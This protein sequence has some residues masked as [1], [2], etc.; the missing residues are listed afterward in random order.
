[1]K[2]NKVLLKLNISNTISVLFF[3]CF[4]AFAKAQIDVTNLKFLPIKEGVSK[5]PISTILQD[6]QGFIWIGTRGSGLYRYDGLNFESYK[7]V[8]GD[9]T[10][11]NSNQIFTMYLDSSDNLWVG[12]DAGLNLFNREQKTF[13]DI[14]NIDSTIQGYTTITAIIEDQD[15]N[16]IVGTYDNGIFKINSKT[17]SSSK[18]KTS[19]ELEGNKFFTNDLEIGLSGEWFVATSS[20]LLRYDLKADAIES[21]KKEEVSSQNLENL[22]SNI[23]SLHKDHLD[24]LWIGTWKKGLLKLDL[25]NSSKVTSFPITNEKIFCLTS[26]EDKIFLGTENDGLFVISNEGAILHNYT[27]NSN[28]TGSIKSNSI[29]SI[30]LDNKERIW[31]GYYNQGVDLYNPLHS[32]FGTIDALSGNT[33]IIQ[34]SPITDIVIDTQGLLRISTFNTVFS[35]D[36]TTKIIEDYNEN[37]QI[38]T[39]FNPDIGIESLFVDSNNNFWI[40]TWDNGIYFLENGSQKFVNYNKQSTKGALKTNTIR[41]FAEDG[42]GRVWMA[43][44]LSGLHYYDPLNKS[45]NHCDN[46]SFITSG[47]SNSD[48]KTIIID[49]YNTIWVGSTNGLFKIKDLGNSTFEAENMKPKME[50]VH[51]NHPSLHNILSL[52]ETEDGTIWIGT[53]G[54]GLL[55]YEYEEDTFYNQNLLSNIEEKTVNGIIEDQQNNLWICGDLGV[56]KLDLSTNETTNFTTY[57]GLLS[58]YFRNGVLA[59]ATSGNLYFGNQLGVNYI[60][61]TNYTTNK[62]KPLLYLT[63]FKL[64]NKSIAHHKTNS[65][66]KKSISE[67]DSITLK[68]DQN[69]FSIDFVGVNY[70]RAEKNEYAYILEGFDEQ[71]NYVGSSK[72]ASYTN[73]NSGAYT[74]KLKAA[75]NDGVWTQTPLELYVSITPPWWKTAGAYLFYFLFALGSFVLVYFLSKRRFKE[76]QVTLLERNQRLQEE[77]LHQVKLKFFTNISHEFRTPLTLII[78]P[79]ND[80]VSKEK[81]N[82]PK[83]VNKKL[84]IIHKNSYRLSLLIN[85]LM[86]FRKLQ[87][88]KLQILPKE[89]DIVETLKNIKMF[90]KEEKKKRNI[91]LKL[92][93]TINELP[94]LVDPS[95][96]EKIIFN[97]LSN[98][99]KVTPDGGSIKIVLKKKNKTSLSMPQEISEYFVISVKDSGSGL[100]QKEYNQIFKRFYQVSTN[101]KNYYGST[102]IGLEMVK[103]Y[104]NLHNGTIEVKSKIG[105]GAK[106]IMKFP[107]VQSSS[108]ANTS[109]I[110]NILDENKEIIPKVKE[111]YTKEHLTENIAELPKNQKHTVLIVED[112]IELQEYIQNELNLLYN[113]LVASNGEVG[114]KIALEKQPD[115][116]IT[117]VVMPLVN[118]IEL[119]KNIKTNIATNHIPLIILTAKAMI[120]DRIKGIDSGAD[121]YLSKPFDMDLLKSMINQIIVNR[122]VLFNKYMSR[123][124]TANTKTANTSTITLNDAFLKRVIHLIHER[125]DDQNLNVENLADQL[126]LS[127]SQLYRK[128]KVVTGF[129]ASEFLRKVRLEKARELLQSNYNYNISE[130]TY[131]VGFSSPSY[132]TKCFKREFGYLPTEEEIQVNNAEKK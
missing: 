21:F 103:D 11:L 123:K 131:K 87:S 43:S 65:V 60:N 58:H 89:I 46:D 115:I 69:F 32:K 54:M 112:N 82:L 53:E 59:K 127:R 102:G 101:N 9:S 92:E 61:P 34:S 13:L 16:L 93:T 107:L 97:I 24:N 63:D 124:K 74:F 125:I 81:K 78:N 121:G 70:T 51:Q 64:F 73:L 25:N 41:G 95:M 98:A 27:E 56:S 10:S 96:F 30:F 18:V 8:W 83:R 128:I 75:N 42:E 130:V 108:F 67:T 39:D 105:K 35:Y 117:D 80:L 57:D 33:N 109:T 113:T 45:F 62:N 23:E 104:I 94:A 84:K 49:S 3:F 40:G 90:F 114:F 110:L 15:G 88:N 37:K 38:T 4:F 19:L 79:I 14:Q 111:S 116:I 119:C 120:E 100:D 122:K 28:Y 50:L 2:L 132:F 52:Y 48:V 6:D 71:W 66:L 12:T 5:K 22:T 77:E 72:S 44:F 47:L 99:F 85:E 1:M 20:G 68:Y 36:P 118:G 29:W 86:D 91:N 76:K 129:S 106:F 55:R 26:F 31:L 126:R 7:Q 17:Y